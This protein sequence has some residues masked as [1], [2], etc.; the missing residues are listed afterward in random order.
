MW[1]EMH[2]KH[3]WKREYDLYTSIIP[4]DG[5]V[6]GGTCFEVDIVRKQN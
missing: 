3:G 4:C 2:Y 5:E 6:S 1:V